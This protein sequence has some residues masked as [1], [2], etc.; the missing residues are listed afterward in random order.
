MFPVNSAGDAGRADQAR[1]M[2]V[3]RRLMATGDSTAW[4]EIATIGGTVVSSTAF[5][6][7]FILD[8]L[9]K[10][11]RIFYRVISRH[12]KEDDDAFAMI[13]ESIHQ[14][15]VRNAIRDETEP[16]P[17]R[18]IPRRRYLVTEPGEQDGD[19]DA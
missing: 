8:Q 18:N 9:A 5:L 10:N 7:W 13:Q 17:R 6:T 12:N 14:I 4:F 2:T 16:P 3:E 1:L 11:R 15:Q 19:L